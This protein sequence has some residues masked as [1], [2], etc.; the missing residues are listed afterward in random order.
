MKAND[1]FKL[2][3][4]SVV[5]QLVVLYMLVQVLVSRFD[6]EI[7]I[8]WSIVILIAGSDIASVVLIYLFWDRK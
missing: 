2:E 6:V 5:V 8:L 7:E 1:Y 4:I 3:A